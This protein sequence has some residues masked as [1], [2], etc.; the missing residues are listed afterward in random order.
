M[1]C[2]SDRPFA[3]ERDIALWVDSITVAEGEGGITLSFGEVRLTDEALACMHR[4][5]EKNPDNA[6]ALNYIGYTWAEKGVKLDEAEEMISRAIEL[7]P[8]DGYIVDSL[9]WV[10]YM[11]ARPLVD[12]GRSQEARLLLGRAIAELERASQNVHSA[13][14]RQLRRYREVSPWP[15][16]VGYKQ[17]LSPVYLSQVYRSG[18]TGVEYAKRWL[19]AHGL[20]TFTNPSS[21]LPALSSHTQMRVIRCH[22]MHTGW[23]TRWSSI[24]SG[25]TMTTT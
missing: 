22:R 21:V 16:P 24:D 13:F 6:S 18:T 8:E 14:L 10:Y 23:T 11:R 20:T 7:R 1:A 12:D 25:V 17:R 19:L 15:M 5:L 9:G 4:A 2:T 3:T